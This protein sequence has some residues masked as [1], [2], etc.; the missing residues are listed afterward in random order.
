MLFSEWQSTIGATTC[1]FRRNGASC[2]AQN[3]MPQK[4][5]PI[6]YAVVGLGEIS[7][8]AV[9]PG[10]SHAENS[11][12]VA[13]VSSDPEKQKELGRKYGVSRMV[14][15]DGYE[16][17]LRSGEID[18]VYIA[19][20]NHLH[21]EYTVRA[22]R[23][24]VHVLCEKPMAVTEDECLM[25]TEE[26]K[27]AGVKLMIA[28]RLHFEQSNLDS[29][30][31]AQSG[32]LGE[33]RLFHSLFSQEVKHMEDVRL[34]YDV[35]Q[36][37][38][39][40]YDMGIY[41]INAARY[42]LRDEPYEV[43]AT[44]ASS[45]DPRF[46]KV[47]EAVSVTMQFPKDRLATFT[48]SFGA[49][50]NSVYNVTGTKGS[51][52]LDPAYG[53]TEEVKQKLTVEGHKSER[54]FSKHDQFAAELIYFSDC[55]LAD[56][57]PEPSGEEGLADVQII[58]AIHESLSTGKPVPLV[59]THSSHRPGPDQEISRPPVEEPELVHAFTP[60]GN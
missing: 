55:I 52:Q 17:L 39:P 41:C 44:A 36:G 49:A 19:L 25:M 58:R 8:E 23:A 37:G 14:S 56:K 46:A 16:E 47:P 5:S 1:T 24:G 38:G 6:R 42:L 11:K 32:V 12:L 7:Q 40:I 3:H 9:L 35:A 29:I 26:C 21:A 51:L 34:K 30:R 27:N 31:I 4:T 43:V 33:L 60:G 59:I 10:F 20:P 2:A 15:Y 50:S 48:A 22:A 57:E 13:F 45:D 28:Y 53:Y 18:A 54:T